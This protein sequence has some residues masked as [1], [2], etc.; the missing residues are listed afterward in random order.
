MWY[1]RNSKCK[2]LG[3]DM[4]CLLFYSLKPLGRE[5][6][7]FA[8]QKHARAKQGRSQRNRSVAVP[9]PSSIFTKALKPLD[10]DHCFLSRRAVLHLHFWLD[11]VGQDQVLRLGNHQGKMSTLYIF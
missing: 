1:S 7:T 6:P 10:G 4:L 11:L 8:E 2:G 9:L 5:V 3:F